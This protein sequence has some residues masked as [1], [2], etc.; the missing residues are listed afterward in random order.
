MK[1]IYNV[2]CIA[3]ACSL[4]TSCAEKGWGVEG[5]VANAPE[6]AK[7]AV[8]GFNAGMWYNIDSVEVA[9]DGSFRYR[10]EAGSPY[11]DI[12]RVS[13]DGKS[14]YFPIDSLETVTVATEAATFDNGYTLGGSEMAETMMNVD[15]RI[16]GVVTEKGALA[17]V[18]DSVL[19]RE[20]STII[21]EDET[22]ILGYYIVNKT[23]GDMPL[24]SPANRG[25]LRVIGALANNFHTNRPNDPRT[26]YL[27]SLYLGARR[28]LYPGEQQGVEVVANETGLLDIE[29]FD[30]KGHKRKLSDV[31]A[32][33]GITVLSFTS[34]QIEPSLAYNAELKRLQDLFAASNLSIYQVSLDADEVQWRTVASNLPWT[35]VW[36]DNADRGTL[37]NMYNVGAL[38]MTY[39]IDRNGDLVE[40]VIDPADLETS[41]RKHIK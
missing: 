29:L 40:R 15:A 26:Q 1:T 20:L 14:I 21:N 18:A 10:A 19:K 35:A 22:G 36:Y 3:A 12:Y 6:G 17:A 2:I 38:P 34:Y 33:S 23:V 9:P 16:A 31:A 28:E 13:F 27:I 25:D 4:M 5:K 41:I 39:I 37:I 8:E 30:P 7:L 24:F 11:P 32:S